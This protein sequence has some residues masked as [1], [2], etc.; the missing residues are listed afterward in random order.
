MAPEEM[1]EG[2]EEIEDGATGQDGNG[3]SKNF[4]GTKFD[5]AKNGNA[6]RSDVESTTIGASIVTGGTLK[7]NH[8]RND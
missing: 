7:D 4:E 8:R 6:N 1:I 3:N 5:G 2:E